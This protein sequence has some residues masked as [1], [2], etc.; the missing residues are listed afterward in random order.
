MMNE[1]EK[2]VWQLIDQEITAE[3]FAKLEKIFLQ[4]PKLRI[5]FQDCLE[6]ENS[7]RALPSTL[8]EDIVLS[9]EKNKPKKRTQYNK[10]FGWVAAAVILLILLIDQRPELE[11]TL[12]A[13]EDMD[14]RGMS[15]K[16]GEIM[17]TRMLHLK[18]GVVELE[19][20]TKTNV[21]IEAP[22]FFQVVN[23][24]SLEVGQ[25]SLTITHEG[26]PGSFSLLTPTGI[27]QD[28][29]TKFGVS[30]GNSNSQSTVLTHVFEGKVKFKDPATERQIIFQNGEY[31]IIQ[32]RNRESPYT[33]IPNDPY[34]YLLPKKLI[35]T[36]TT[37]K[38]LRQ[39]LALNKPVSASGFW[40]RG[41]NEIFPPSKI[42][43][44]RLNDKGT[45][46]NWSFWLLE[47]NVT[48]WV[49]IDL[50]K[51]EVISEVAFQNTHNRG[52]QDRAA[53]EV[54]VDISLDNIDFS[55]I[56]RTELASSFNEDI[57]DIPIQNFPI[58]KVRARYVRINVKSFHHNGGGLN[59]VKLY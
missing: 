28:L 14:W 17:P 47:N 44:G 7:L 34:A 31:A 52:Y 43:D 41:Q 29:G 59:E 23:N 48:G 49:T 4:D 21:I 25:G 3:D 26:K 13:A 2:L 51:P 45:P 35:S 38:P 50:E 57:A 16:V 55:E 53:K 1:N 54:S 8:S 27:L 24:E 15:I 22:A 30:I 42:N 40:S 58:P 10:W 32:G 12:V 5:Y 37:E 19:F 56:L 33:I 20:P 6:T 36:N 18:N 11:V 39:N 46:G 9:L